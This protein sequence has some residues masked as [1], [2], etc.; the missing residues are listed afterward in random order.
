MILPLIASRR[1]IATGVLACT[2]LFA[3]CK[4]APSVSQATPPPNADAPRQPSAADFNAFLQTLLPPVMKVADL[5]TD[6][7]TRMPDTSADGNTWIITVKLTL[8]PAEDLLALPSPEDAHV[9][10]GLAAEL[11]ALIGWRNAYVGSPYARAYGSFDV[12][13]PTAPAPQLL[14]VRQPQGKPLN[15][16]YGKV[17]A[18][19]EV[20]HWAFSNIDLELPTLGQPRA[21]FPGSTMVKG[22][23]EAVTFVETEQK[24]IAD[25]K[26]KK[27]AIESSF[28]KDLLAATKPGTVYQGQINHHLGVLPCTLR[29]LDQPPGGDTQMT[30][31]ELRLTNEPSYQLVYTAKLLIPLP[32]GASS[33]A[34]NGGSIQLPDDASPAPVGNLTVN[35]SHGSGQDEK[36]TTLPGMVLRGQTGRYTPHDQPFLIV[37]HQLRGLVSRYVNGEFVLTATEKR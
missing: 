22:S 3:G 15:P 21:S 33:A 34:T 1:S 20:D 18:E 10:D 14:V 5:K 29:F 4:P 26:Q 8:S 27:A 11:N 6:P 25:A 32:L 16:Q 30:M 17:A 35:F 28:T 24:A 12:A 13:V 37:G 36:G 2:L 9:I 7:P 23:P 19:W 31:F